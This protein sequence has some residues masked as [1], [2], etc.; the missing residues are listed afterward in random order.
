M[1][2][3]TVQYKNEIN[4]IILPVNVYLM[5]CKHEKVMPSPEA[6]VKVF[7]YKVALLSE[8]RNRDFGFC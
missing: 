4:T 2:D 6:M 1:F 8:A 5:R 3:K 7:K